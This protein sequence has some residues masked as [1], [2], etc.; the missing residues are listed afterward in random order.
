MKQLFELLKINFINDLGIN[1][2]RKYKLFKK[3]AIILLVVYILASLTTSICV[4]TAL[5]MD[6]LA[7]YN[8]TIFMIPMIFLLIYFVSF[9]FTIYNAKASLFESKDNNLLLSMPIKKITIL[10]SKI[11]KLLGI[12]LLLSLFILIPSS[13]IYISRVHVD[14]TFYLYTI[15]T[16]LFVTIIPTTLASLFGYLVAYLT[17]KSN[18]KNI[19]EVLLSL[20]FI[21]GIYYGMYNGQ[22]ILM[23]FINDKETVLN[24]IKYTFYPVYL[25]IEVFIENNIKSLFIFIAINILFISLFTYIMSIKYKNI[26][27]KL[28][29]NKTKSNYKMA[30][31]KIEKPSKAL[32]IKEIKRYFSSPIY[33]LNTSFGV[34]MMFGL[35]LVTI[36]YDKTKIMETLEMSN[37]NV[38][39]FQLLLALILMVTFMSN[40]TSVSISL[41]GQNFWII[42][43]LPIEIKKIF[44]IKILLNLIVIIPAA[45]ISIIIFK[46]TLG[47]TIIEVLLL[48]LLTI[49]FSIIT[50]YFGLLIN[51]K[52][53]KMDAQNDTV[54]VK[55]SLSVMITILVPL[56]I[57]VIL[58]GII[59]QYIDIIN[60]NITIIITVLI[61]IIIIYIENKLLNKYGF[62]LFKKI[63]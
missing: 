63:N 61:S 29:E 2:I 51:L 26:I 20:L 10:S 16:L 59:S 9:M 11:I 4:Y 40:T 8:M 23:Y 55:Q 49:L 14:T 18:F 27:S 13:I 15:L 25:I 39:N 5:I 43:S 54:V 36:F 42:K 6:N 37:I 41:E 47:I 45:I 48:I 32:L 31:L 12:N 34:I 22:K 28:S 24:I 60:F 57:N 46:F 33:L 38:N 44:N 56:F 1:K 3:L 7:K 17:S 50:A 21:F 62:K 52:F 35:A 30:K 58:I 53:H 19:A